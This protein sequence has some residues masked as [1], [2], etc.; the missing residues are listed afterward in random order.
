MPHPA[1]MKLNPTLRPLGTV[2][3]R[4]PGFAAEV[5]EPERFRTEV[6]RLRRVPGRGG[7]RGR[8]RAWRRR[9]NPEQKMRAT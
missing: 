3:D 8:R 9:P 6:P 2:T 1:G 4:T 7:T 5:E